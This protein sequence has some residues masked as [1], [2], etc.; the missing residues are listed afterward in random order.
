MGGVERGAQRC[1]VAP[2]AIVAGDAA[3]TLVACLEDV[4]V[5][6][7]DRREQSL[8]GRVQEGRDIARPACQPSQ[9]DE[10]VEHAG[11]ALHLLEERRVLEGVARDAAE[12]SDELQIGGEISRLVV[13]E[14]HEAEHA[15]SRQE[16]HRKLRLIAP[17]LER[18]TPVAGQ[19]LVVQAGGDH[20]LSR[21]H[22]SPAAGI[23]LDGDDHALPLVVEAPAVVADQGAQRVPLDGVDVGDRGLRQ[24]GETAYHCVQHVVGAEAGGVFAVPPRRPQRDR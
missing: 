16:R 11:A 24:L 1:L 21:L 6:G 2:A 14:L 13:G 22:G 7:V 12:A 5:G 3:Q 20:D 15:A 17:F 10:L 23:P 4:A 18:V 9:L 8:G 19:Q